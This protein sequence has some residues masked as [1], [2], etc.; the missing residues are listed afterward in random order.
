MDESEKTDILRLH[1]R[2][3]TD[4]AQGLA[5][6]GLVRPL[7]TTGTISDA[8]PGK[9]VHSAQTT[10]GGSGEEVRTVLG[11]VLGLE[12]TPATEITIPDE[13]TVEN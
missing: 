11:E 5:E 13:Q 10:E 9:I 8:L 1:R 12:V 4:V 6:R 7:T 3:V 2:S